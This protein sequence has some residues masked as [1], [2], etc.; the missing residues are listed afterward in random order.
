MKFSLRPTGLRRY[1]RKHL[2]H[3]LD[4]ARAEAL[5]LDGVIRERDTTVRARDERISQLEADVVDVSVERQLRLLAEDKADDYE[6]RFYELKATFDNEHAIS[7]PP[8]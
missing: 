7:L 1:T 8:A 3:D 5:R 6:R 2:R 4:A